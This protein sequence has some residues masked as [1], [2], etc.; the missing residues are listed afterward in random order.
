MHPGSLVDVAGL[1]V[2]HFTDPRRPTGCSVVLCEAGATCGVDVRGAAPG[3]RETDLL[4]PRNV[5]EHVHA[6]LLSGGS[7]FGLAAADGVMRWLEERGV[8][9]EVGPARVPIVP[10]AVLFDLWL[11]DARIRPDAAAGHAACAAASAAA[12]AQGSVGAGAGATVG[13]L[14]GIQH[15]MKGGIGSASIRVGAITVAALVAVNAI[16]DVIDPATGRIVAGARADDG[17]TPRDSM[18]AIRSG[19]L[20][21]RLLDGMA[22]T[23]GVVATDARLTKAQASK[24]ASMA[25]DGLAR[26][27]NPVHTLTDGDTLFALATGTSGRP[28]HLTVLGALAAEV[29]ARAVINAVRAAHGLDDPPLPAARDLGLA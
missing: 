21:A 3:T 11:G 23:I 16:G 13:K 26:S 24:L 19:A 20:P 10:A 12:P 2:G 14:F 27:I 17:R 1:K 28:G 29:T 6:V 7:A 25:H 18:A 4:D 5:I 15:A 22:T 8:G 9:I